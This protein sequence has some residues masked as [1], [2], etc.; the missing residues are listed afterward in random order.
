MAFNPINQAEFLRR[1]GVE[2]KTFEPVRRLMIE[3]GDAK[4][5]AEPKS[6]PNYVFDADV[7]WRYRE[8][9]EKRKALIAIGHPG[10]HSKRPY[11]L[12]DMYNLV[13]AGTL[14]GEIDHPAF[15]VANNQK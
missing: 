8:Y 2:R 3:A 14:D 6:Q 13:D 1:L 4:N 9:L 10:W 12:E 7:L 5:I 11:S 15:Q